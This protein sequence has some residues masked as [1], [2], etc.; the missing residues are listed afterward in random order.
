MKCYTYV[1]THG[2]ATGLFF[3][4]DD[5]ALTEQDAPEIYNS[6]AVKELYPLRYIDYTRGGIFIYP[7]PNAVYPDAANGDEQLNFVIEEKLVQIGLRQRFNDCRSLVKFVGGCRACDDRGR[8]CVSKA[9]PIIGNPDF[10]W[11]TRE[12]EEVLETCKKKPIASYQYVSPVLTKQRHCHFDTA[13]RYLREHDFNA[14]TRE[15]WSK[16]RSDASVKAGENRR[17]KKEHCSICPVEPR[18][19]SYRY[20]RGPYPEEGAS[21]NIVLDIWHARLE[22]S[23]ISLDYFW[24]VASS[25]GFKNF[26]HNRKKSSFMGW[27][28]KDGKFTYMG[29]YNR[30]AERFALTTEDLAKYELLREHGE[31]PPSRLTQAL[32]FMSLSVLEGPTRQGHGWGYSY[33]WHVMYRNIDNGSLQIG[34]CDNRGPRLTEHVESISE[35]FAR[36]APRLPD[37][38]KRK[39]RA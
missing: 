20:C 29:M 19:G 10:G 15:S 24:R 16:L 27:H 26:V 4:D 18:C 2:V 22:D 23:G 28:W 31:G 36:L 1:A 8:N 6:D 7:F 12:E 30:R 35:F 25:G 13:H 39:V 5:R 17:F 3:Y 21:I 9:I 32:Y 11:V 33:P 37:L 38:T 14:D 34:W